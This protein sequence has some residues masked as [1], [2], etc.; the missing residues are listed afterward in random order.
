MLFRSIDA[1]VDIMDHGDWACRQHIESPRAPKA[2]K[3]GLDL[4]NKICAKGK[5]HTNKTKRAAGIA[6]VD[7][8]T[9]RLEE[10]YKEITDK[11]HSTG[12]SAPYSVQKKKESDKKHCEA[13]AAISAAASTAI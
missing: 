4:V 11:S 2:R 5:Q 3:R 9:H 7:N 10:K 12:A 8:N 1:M 13:Q 6:D